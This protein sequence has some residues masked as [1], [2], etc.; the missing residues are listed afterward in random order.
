MISASSQVFTLPSRSDEQIEQELLSLKVVE[1]SQAQADKFLV[2]PVIDL[3]CLTDGMKFVN[4]LS[5][6]ITHK[7][8]I[9]HFNQSLI[10]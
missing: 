1:D 8:H 10:F 6:S 5:K 4:L 2:W 3:K 9:Y 7:V